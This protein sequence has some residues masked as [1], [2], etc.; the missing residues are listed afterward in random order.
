MT[1]LAAGLRSGLIFSTLWVFSHRSFAVVLDMRAGVTEMSQRIQTL[2][3][4]SLWVCVVVGIV[5]FDP[6]FMCSMAP[7]AETKEPE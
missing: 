3:Q 4:I 5:V 6:I 1:S 7:N 2:H